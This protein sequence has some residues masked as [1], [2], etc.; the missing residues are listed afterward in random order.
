MYSLANP[1]YMPITLEPYKVTKQE[2]EQKE[3]CRAYADQVRYH[4]I[5]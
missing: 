1:C 2:F 5:T 3:L 4:N